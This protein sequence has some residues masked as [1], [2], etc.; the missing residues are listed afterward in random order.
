MGITHSQ[1]T[2]MSRYSLISSLFFCIAIVI[3]SCSSGHKRYESEATEFAVAE[4]KVEFATEEHEAAD[5]QSGMR[6]AISSSAATIGRQDSSRKFI[7]TVDIRFKTKNVV[8]AVYAIED[9][10]AKHRGF[11]QHSNLRSNRSHV[12]NIKISKD[13]TLELT[14]Y[15][16]VNE[17]I[18]RVPSAELDVMLKGIVPWIDYLDYREIRA[19]DV[20]LMLLKNQLAQKRE[21]K[22]AE[23]IES[24]I[25]N[26][27]KKLT[28]TIE[29][30]EVRQDRE[31]RADEA[32]IS[33]FS[34]QDKI[35]YSTI[36]LNIYQREAVKKELIPNE[37]N[38]D[39]YQPSFGSRL[40]EALK[41]GGNAIIEVVLFI[42][43]LWAFILVGVLI[44]VGIKMWKK[45][46]KDKN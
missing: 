19:D 46:K 14:Y 31:R 25:D 20:S 43:N 7:R 32:V 13:S 11:I 1:P 4:E 18:I 26:R 34:M 24:A 29:G 5:N 21:R 23:R 10:A 9:I 36:T 17:M 28:E 6:T 8:Q 3:Y 30:E 42:A 39:A 35:E 33:N 12:E 45:R 41:W 15:T 37:K 16:I 27:G 44:F 22:G 2:K 40:L 38:I